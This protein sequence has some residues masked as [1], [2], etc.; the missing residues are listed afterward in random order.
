MNRLSVEMLPAQQGDAILIEYGDSTDLHHVLIDAGTSPSFSAV[1]QRLQSSAGEPSRLELLIVSHIDTDHIGGVLRLLSDPT[2]TVQIDEVWFNGWEHLPAV[3]SD[4][5]GPVDGEILS[6][7]LR[8]RKIPLNH[9]FEGGAVGV[10]EEGPVRS[11]TLRGGLTLTVLSPGRAQLTNLRK[12]WHRVLKAAGLDP[13]QPQGLADAQRLAQLAARKGVN[14]DVLGGATPDVPT[15]AALP[16]DTD[17][18]VANGSSIVVLAEYE[19]KSVLLGADAFP[20]V[21]A[22]SVSRLLATRVTD[23]LRIDAFKVCH[24][25]SKHN[26]ND[27]LLGMLLCPRYLYS[28]NGNI[29]GHPDDE[30]VARAVVKGGSEP[31]LYFNYATE[32]NE[33]WADPL[34]MRRAGFRAVFPT[35]G[36]SGLCVVL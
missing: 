24:H 13:A 11:L 27:D 19:G 31:A 3:R 8:M 23:R 4:R 34:L 29:F 2:F 9:A 12:E 35:A 16:F 28:T 15:L 25:G 17:R 7:L 5:L 14:L 6:G 20:E 21:V 30:A 1:E 10:P 32:H 26:T 18:A 22:G 33:M 36:A